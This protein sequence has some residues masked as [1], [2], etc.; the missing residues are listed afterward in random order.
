MK[1]GFTLI[2]LLAVIVILAIIAL[3][4]T[5][6][7]LNIIKETRES[8]GLRSAEMYLDAVEQVI[9][10]EKMNN[11]NFKSNECTITDKGNLD[12]DT[13]DGILEVKVNGEKPVDGKITFEKG[14]IK[15]VNLEY[16]N[17]K[18]IVMN[19]EGKL[20]YKK[21]I[22]ISNYQHKHID[23]TIEDHEVT[24]D[25]NGHGICSICMEE[26]LATGLYDE[27]DNLVASWGTLVNDYGLDIT[28]DG[29]SSAPLEIQPTSSIT[30]VL[31]NSD[32]ANGVKLII[33]NDVNYIGKAQFSYSK[34]KEVVIPNNGTTIGHSAFYNC[35]NLTTITLEGLST[36]G[37]NAFY[38]CESL[39]EIEI[40]SEKIEDM[41]FAACYSLTT[42]QISDNVKS[43]G[44][45]VF[46]GCTKLTSISVDENNSV[47]DSRDNCNAVIESKTNTLIAGCKTTKIL[48]DVINI[49]NYAFGWNAP[50]TI[51]LPNS[52]TSI[53]SNAFSGCT[54]LT[55]IYYSGT[56]EDVNGNN[57]GAT[58]ATIK[59]YSEAPKELLP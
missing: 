31:T 59:P 44:H 20:Q 55:T 12:C 17:D 57:W 45:S 53:S 15:D 24:F 25:S 51:A 10:V 42:V 58:N 28:A 5:P 50:D 23:G 19:I 6:I 39:K 11:P 37:A 47:Y 9:S 7:V 40:D 34:I 41:V 3:I 35:S 22:S 8:A 33:S 46:R 36:I 56:A 49:G 18:V 48:E 13:K 32:L 27:N 30:Q 54:N 43:I 1:K 2:E 26:V 16:L 21:Y 29:V 38:F 4:A 52:V 14:K